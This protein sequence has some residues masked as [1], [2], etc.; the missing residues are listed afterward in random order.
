MRL[1]NLN[2]TNFIKYIGLFMSILMFIASLFLWVSFTTLIP[3]FQYSFIFEWSNYLNIWLAFGIDG[4]SLF[5]IIL[6]TFIMPI[7]ILSVW[8]INYRC[9]E[10]ISCLIL[11][12]IFLI[13]AFTV[14]DLFLFYIAFESV[15]IPMFIIVG[16][17]GSRARKIKAAYFF[18]LYTLTGSFLMLFS[19]LVIYLEVG[20]TAYDVL[21][22][23]VFDFEKQKMLWICFFIAFAVKIP[24]FPFHIWLPEAHVEAPTAGSVIL[25]SLLLKLGGYGFIRYLIPICPQA[26]LYFLPLVYTLTIISILYASLTTLRQIDLKKII[27]YSSIAHMNLVVLGIFSLN[28]QG[29]SG[30]ILLMLGHGIISGALFLM[31]GV[32]YDRYHNRLIRYYGGLTML[33]PVFSICFLLF[34]L[35]NLA[36]PGTFNFVG[37]ALILCGIF[38][39]NTTVAT[40]VCISMVFSAS[41]SL[42]M[43]AR[44]AFGTL[45]VKYITNYLDM[46]EREIYIIGPLVFINILMGVYPNIVL[47]LIYPSVKYYIIFIYKTGF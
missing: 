1:M 30:S 14:L 20:T 8:N 44:V 37:E 19:I 41:Y 13:A 25:A 10:Y 16:V 7:C 23:T 22:G 11:L 36:L 2:N 28:T 6:T 18:F 26:T 9:A 17:W 24:M 32:L 35:S 21:L 45:K 12:E 4:I 47:D 38:Q 43:Y 31:V 42:W 46:V 5:F 40:I 39:L 3:S 27:A 34:N 15:L 33:M 29:V